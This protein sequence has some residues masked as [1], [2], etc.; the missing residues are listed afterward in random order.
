[1]LNI[2]V[3]FIAYKHIHVSQYITTCIPHSYKIIHQ[4]FHFHQPSICY[5]H[6]WNQDTNY[7]LYANM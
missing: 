6:T 5:R 7:S 1:M 3:Y 4:H 2:H